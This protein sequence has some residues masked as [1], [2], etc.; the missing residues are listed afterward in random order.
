M[1]AENVADQQ[2]TAAQIQRCLRMVCGT[3]VHQLPRSIKGR[4]INDL[5]L[6]DDSG[7]GV[8]VGEDAHIQFVFDHADNAGIGDHR[9]ICTA[10][11]MLQK[12][13]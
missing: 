10:N 4:F 12:I 3:I 7:F 2:E 13:V 8:S 5:K 1:T 11:P 9:T 6:R